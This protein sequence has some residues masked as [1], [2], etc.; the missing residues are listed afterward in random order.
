MERTLRSENS[1]VTGVIWKQLLF[2]FFPIMLGSLFQQLYNTV[3]AIVVGQFVGTDALAAVGGS[4]SNI[5]NLLIGF[6]TGVSSGATVIISQYYGANDR[7]GVNRA[8]HTAMLFAVVGGAILTVFG[9]FAAE[10]VLRLMDTPEDTLAG[11]A[12]YLRIMFVGMIPNMIYNVGSAIL[13]AMGDSKRPLYFLVVACL[14]NVV[15][16]LV[17]VLVFKMGIAGV[18]IAS[19]MAQAISAV[20]VIMSLSSANSEFRFYF[21]QM[22]FEK[23]ILSRTIKIGLP[24]GFQSIMYSLS[25]M[26][27]QASINRF[28]TDTVASWVVLGKVDG[29][30]WMI[31]GA[32]GVAS[33]T[34]VGQ[35]YG[36]GRLDRIRKSLKLSLL[37]GGCIT[38]GIGA[39]LLLFG[40]PLF[41]LFTTDAIVLD[42]AIKLLT[43]FAPFY[44]LFV[45]IEIFSG[46][47][48]GMGDTLIPTIIT[49]TGICVFRVVW[50][51]TVVPVYHSMLTV[52]LSYPIS[53]VLT[54]AAFIV[55]YLAVRKKL[56]ANA[57]KPAALD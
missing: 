15:L 1:M 21:K 39:I 37:I 34:F 20:M 4:A 52:S 33:M 23:D 5:L 22:R 50:I 11:S 41:K 40:R 28:G 42:M 57:P 54:S 17:F 36:A 6:F 19:I 45:P 13:R 46:A 7:D 27:I 8:L 29:V 32:L 3:D 49:A 30:T 14:A 2:F 38:G 9:L 26:L 35:N 48:R 31:L 12:L 16:D 10:F 24:A 51:Y 56:I 18:A 53:W 44:W 43:Y 55:Y 25:N 47:L